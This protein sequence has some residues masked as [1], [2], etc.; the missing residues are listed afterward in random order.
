MFQVF[1]LKVFVSTIAPYKKLEQNDPKWRQIRGPLE[2]HS[3]QRHFMND[4]HAS[5]HPSFTLAS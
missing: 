1:I 4:H 3:L 2:V 5:W